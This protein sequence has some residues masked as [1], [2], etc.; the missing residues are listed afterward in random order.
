M[1][2]Y[3]PVCLTNFL[4]NDPRTFVWRYS[5]YC[6]YA[7][8]LACLCTKHFTTISDFLPFRIPHQNI[9][10]SI[11][12]WINYAI[13]AHLWKNIDDSDTN[14]FNRYSGWLNQI[15]CHCYMF[16]WIVIIFFQIDFLLF[17]GFTILFIMLLS[18]LVFVLLLIIIDMW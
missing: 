17:S 11:P 13:H 1:Y 4:S 12:K 5:A 14:Y 16:R 7:Y 15:I 10:R 18:D 9:N 3:K 2:C 6:Q 8:T